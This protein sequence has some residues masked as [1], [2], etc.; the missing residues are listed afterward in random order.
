[1]KRILN[2]GSGTVK[3]VNAINVDIH[4]EVSPD[5]VCDLNKFPYPF[6][7]GSFERIIMN[8]VLEHLDELS[9][10]LQ[11]CSRLLTNK[12]ILEIRAP[13]CS[14]DVALGDRFHKRVINDYTVSGHCC[15]SGE[16]MAEIHKSNFIVR[17]KEIR[18]DK[19]FK[20]LLHV[21]KWVKNFGEN[22]LRNV[23]REVK[24][25]LQKIILLVS[26]TYD[27][28]PS[29]YTGRVLDKLKQ[30]NIKAA[31]FVLGK[32]AEI[33]PDI[34]RRIVKEGHILGIHGYDH[35][36]WTSKEIIESEVQKTKDILK[37]IVPDYEFEYFRPPFVMGYGARFPE[38]LQVPSLKNMCCVDYTVPCNDW[39][40]E[41][42]LK[43]MLMYIQVG[44][45]NMGTILF[46]DG[47]PEQSVYKD[48][49]KAIEILFPLLQYLNTTNYKIV[50]LKELENAA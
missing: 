44:L 4:P 49:I 2:L 36:G 3:M 30:F 21:P 48:R 38:N 27:D 6:E 18:F 40:E 32:N 11:E 47:Y 5:V 7:G 43:Q 45:K 24:Y 22:H 39:K 42:T 17:R 25:V 13:H 41:T 50:T 23:A 16:D 9:L 14:H 8:H 28:G 19:G 12:G 35:K 10:V 29:E 1:M 15:V 33:Y 20:W 46:H 31:F 26:F 37:R 34:I